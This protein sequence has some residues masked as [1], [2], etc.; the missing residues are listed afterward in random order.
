MSSLKSLPQII[1]RQKWKANGVGG[2]GQNIF[3]CNQVTHTRAHTRTHSQIRVYLQLNYG[4]TVL[5]NCLKSVHI[6]Y[7]WKLKPVQI[8]KIIIPKGFCVWTRL[9]YQA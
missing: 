8:L 2:G 9:F 3:W 5:P 4:I 6:H 1:P 7:T